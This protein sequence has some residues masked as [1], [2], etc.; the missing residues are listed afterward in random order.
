MRTC[1]IEEFAILADHPSDM[2]FTQNQDVVQ[3]LPP[4]TA[5]EPFADGICLGG[6]GWRVDQVDARPFDSLFKPQPKLVSL[7][8][9]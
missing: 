9:D 5:N 3:T 2:F 8:T 6:I 4:D 7:I 1:A